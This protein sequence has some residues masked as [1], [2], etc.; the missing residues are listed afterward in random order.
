M[1]QNG[2]CTSCLLA[3]LPNGL[4]S[5]QMNWKG[6]LEMLEPWEEEAIYTN[7]KERW[8][9]RLPVCK[10]CGEHIQGEY[11]WDTGDGKLCESCVEDDLHLLWELDDEEKPVTKTCQSCGGLIGL[12]WHKQ[13]YHECN[14][15]IICDA[16]YDDAFKRINDEI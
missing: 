3:D 6:E 12:Y 4:A 13:Y 5:R 14:G 2:I 16:C 1:G 9:R 7:R 10:K 8:L 11:L 15:E